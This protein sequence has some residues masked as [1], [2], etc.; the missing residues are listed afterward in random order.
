MKK[1]WQV[2]K[3]QIFKCPRQVKFELI[4]VTTIIKKKK[5]IEKL[6][7]SVGES[8]GSSWV[9]SLSKFET[10]SLPEIDGLKGGAI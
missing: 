7:P 3:V 4:W 9:N 1:V 2:W 10:S 8:F 6:P 5:Q